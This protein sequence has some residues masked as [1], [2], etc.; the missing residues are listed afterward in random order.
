MRTHLLLKPE[1]SVPVEIT[2]ATIPGGWVWYPKIKQIVRF[3]PVSPHSG[4]GQL[5][6]GSAICSREWLTAPPLVLLPRQE[7][8]ELLKPILW[9]SVFRPAQ[10][11]FFKPFSQSGQILCRFRLTLQRK[12]GPRIALPAHRLYYP[13]DIWPRSTT[14]G[15]CGDLRGAP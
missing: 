3:L 6:G 2:Y 9:Q 4:N 14:R 13:V 15:F 5:Q 7:V 1:T 10:P 11:S 8:T 12:S